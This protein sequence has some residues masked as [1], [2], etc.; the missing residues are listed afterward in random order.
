MTIEARRVHRGVSGVL[1]ALALVLLAAVPVANADTIYPDNKLTGS[2]FDAGLDGWTEVSNECT[3]VN[4]LGIE[5]GNLPSPQ[6]LCSPRTDHS[7]GRGN[8]PG[9]LEQ[10]SDQVATASVVGDLPL[11]G[12][13]EGR[14]TAVSPSFTVTT[15]G[16][17]TFQFDRRAQVD[18]LLA[19][20]LIAPAAR[21]EYT[22][23][24]VA[25]AVRTPLFNEVV[26]LD[27]SDDL[28]FLGRI[29]A[30]L[31]VA[32][33]QTYHIELT[34]KV[35]ANPATIASVVGAASTTSACRSLTAP[36][37][38]SHRRPRSPTRRRTSPAFPRRRRRSRRRSARPP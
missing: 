9:S 3:L 30:A 7:A 27:S 10:R 4:L 2:S 17:A 21:V 14:S 36:R 26:N 25:G 13:I 15:G 8:P 19:L 31:N 16:S 23:T 12:L 29:N 24:L 11:L 28:P 34:T 20:G 38:S 35:R 5:I 22:F 33:G 37:R 18:A 6:P 32:T 1:L